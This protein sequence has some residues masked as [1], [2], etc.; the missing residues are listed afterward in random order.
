MSGLSSLGSLLPCTVAYLA[1]IWHVLCVL[2]P[3][4]LVTVRKVSNDLCVSFQ[5]VTMKWRSLS[6]IAGAENVADMP[7]LTASFTPLSD[8]GKQ[9]LGLL[10]RESIGPCG[11]HSLYSDWFQKCLNGITQ[12]TGSHGMPSVM[13][14][15]RPYHLARSAHCHL[16]QSEHS[17]PLNYSHN[18]CQS[19]ASVS[20]YSSSNCST[21][22]SPF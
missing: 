17:R 12:D 8:A 9:D 2:W 6:S 20:H 4:Y 5:V 7:A 13:K 1:G 11:F 14:Q 21:S 15:G 18:H 10:H 3:P 22:N 19:T 16:I